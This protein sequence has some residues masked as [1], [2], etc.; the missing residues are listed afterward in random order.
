MERKQVAQWHCTVASKMD[1]G[2]EADMT[3]QLRGHEEEGPSHVKERLAITHRRM[4][5]HMRVETLD[6]RTIP[7]CQRSGLWV[8]A[9]FLPASLWRPVR[10]RAELHREGGQIC[11]TAPCAQLNTAPS[12]RCVTAVDQPPTEG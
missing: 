6:W 4:H 5:H 3:Q 1:Q 7:M 12:S 8:G 10:P 9:W 11:W 2:R